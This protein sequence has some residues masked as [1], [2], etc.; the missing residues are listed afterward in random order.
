MKQAAVENTVKTQTD[1]SSVEK[2]NNGTKALL[3][4]AWAATKP[5]AIESFP[6]GKG[7]NLSNTGVIKET[8]TGDNIKNS[9]I[10]G[11]SESE[12]KGEIKG[13][14]GK[15]EKGEVKDGGM[16]ALPGFEDADVYLN[17]KPEGGKKDSFRATKKDSELLERAQ[18]KIDYLLKMQAI[19]EAKLAALT[20]PQAAGAEQPRDLGPIKDDPESSADHGHARVKPVWVDGGKPVGTATDQ[21]PELEIT[22]EDR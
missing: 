10:K 2:H 9:G 20:K 11:N 12:V 16:K 5:Q 15:G 19:M 21:L 3:D 13:F 7:K 1:E 22:G 14:G 4:E 18:E 6:G 17:A 8:W